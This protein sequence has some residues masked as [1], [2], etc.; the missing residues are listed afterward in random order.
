MKI[1]KVWKYRRTLI[2]LELPVWKNEYSY[3]LGLIPNLYKKSL[4]RNQASYRNYSLL[5][6]IYSL[7]VLKRF[8]AIHIYRITLQFTSYMAYYCNLHSN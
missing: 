1:C 5:L 7:C 6:L 8:Y 2:Q 3:I 4:K